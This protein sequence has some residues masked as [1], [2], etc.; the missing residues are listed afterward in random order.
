MHYINLF[1]IVGLLGLVSAG[2]IYLHLRRITVTTP[3]MV[4]IADAI[5]H[6][7]DI[8]IDDDIIKGS[9]TVTKTV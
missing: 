9:Y 2:L 7:I 4:E 5:I 3:R 8:K 6:V 1:P